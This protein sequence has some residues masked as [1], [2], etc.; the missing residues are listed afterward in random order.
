MENR[1]EY[2]PG[3]VCVPM[4]DWTWS[5]AAISLFGALSQLPPGSRYDFALDKSTICGKRNR[6]AKTLLENPELEWVLYLDSDMCFPD[7]VAHRLLQVDADVAAGVY[8]CKT[9][10]YRI[11]AGMEVGSRSDD[12]LRPT[13]TSD[14]SSGGFDLDALDRGVGPVE[15]DVV[16]TGCTLIHQEVFETLEAPWFVANERFIDEYGQNED[17]NF[18]LRARDAGFTVALHTDVK[19]EHIGPHGVTVDMALDHQRRV[20][21]NGVEGRGGGSG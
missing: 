20:L 5:K 14:W 4:K 8:P 10:P 15:V 6:A 18:C 11:T 2:P 9:P 1:A 12:P 17:W 13:D 3:L 7:D 21:S 16:A 19:C